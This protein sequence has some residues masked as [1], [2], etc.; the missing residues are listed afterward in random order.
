MSVTALAKVS[1]SLPRAAFGELLVANLTPQYQGTFEY[2][3]DNTD[4]NT[5]T[6]VNGGTVTQSNAK[7]LIGTSTTTA[8]TAL[9]QSKQHAKY[10]SGLGALSRLTAMFTSPVA[11]TEQYVGI[12]DEVG[13]SAAFQNGYAVGYDG[14]TFGFHRW[15][16]D[17]L[18]TVAQADWDDPL[19]GT[20]ASRMTLDQTKLN[21]FQIRFQF[22]GAG[23]I[24][25]WVES[26]T[27]GL[28]VIVHT[29]D[30]TNSKHSSLNL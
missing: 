11:S 24:Q 6:T 8:S 26:D 21:V 14:T 5:N 9:F 3:V 30:Y 25:L 20:G 7:A 17:V 1:E 2:T 29:I 19:D 10:R 4:L 18:T 22:L 12:M 23:A 13:S 28:F 16:N 15:Q 27:T